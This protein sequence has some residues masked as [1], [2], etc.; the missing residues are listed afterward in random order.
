LSKE[1]QRLNITHGRGSDGYYYGL[2][3]KWTIDEP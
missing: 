3:K 1:L 2:R